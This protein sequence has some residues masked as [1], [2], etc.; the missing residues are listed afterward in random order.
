MKIPYNRYFVKCRLL[1]LRIEILQ[2]K[3]GDWMEVSV[4]WGGGGKCY[5]NYPFMLPQIIHLFH[6]LFY[7]FSRP[8][9]QSSLININSVLK[10]LIYH[11]TF[12]SKTNVRV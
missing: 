11:V 2:C 5:M 1:C 6:H 9:Y 8:P 10:I 12:L 3:G 4:F 7:N